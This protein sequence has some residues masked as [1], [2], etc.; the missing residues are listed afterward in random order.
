MVIFDI[1]SSNLRVTCSKHLLFLLLCKQTKPLCRLL[2]D[3]STAT[4]RSIYRYLG[5][6]HIL[7]H[8]PRGRE[9]V[10]EKMTK[11][12]GGGGGGLELD[13]VIKKFKF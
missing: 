13:D 3:I 5:T 12:D 7:R 8:P 9:G 2:T 4:S 6:V 10:L 11:D 1:L